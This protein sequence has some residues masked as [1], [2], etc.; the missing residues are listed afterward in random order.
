LDTLSSRALETAKLKGAQYAD[1]RVVHTTDQ[2]LSVKNGVVDGL[3][4]SESLGIRRSNKV[5]SPMM[6]TKSKAP[7]S[8]PGLYFLTNAQCGPYSYS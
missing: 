2:S 7:T 8:E 3:S 5:L 4:S 6:L 1:I